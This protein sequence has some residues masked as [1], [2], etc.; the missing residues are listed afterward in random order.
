MYLY[1]YV[2]RESVLRKIHKLGSHPTPIR[3]GESKD[4]TYALDKLNEIFLIIESF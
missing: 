1:K 4:P 3:L 2:D